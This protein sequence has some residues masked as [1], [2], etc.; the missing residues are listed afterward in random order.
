MS[1]S[2]R[3]AL[4]DF[5]GVIVDSE[6]TR[7]KTYRTLFQQVYGVRVEIDPLIMVGQPESYNLKG[8]LKS[9]GLDHN[10]KIVHGLKLTRSKILV[11]QAIK[12]FPTIKNVLDIIEH[13]KLMDIPMAIVTNS[14]SDYLF[15]AL[16]SIQFDR[17][18]F[19][20]VTGDDVSAPKPDPQGYLKAVRELGGLSIGGLAFEDSVTGVKA[21]K[22]A[23]LDTVGVL[24][25]HSKMILDTGF[26]MDVHESSKVVAKILSLFGN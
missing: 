7:L 11:D 25:T 4:F 3:Y 21:A 24:S 17:K 20:T 6:P 5:D 10:E 14:S 19:I 16:E 13:L 12:G 15:A 8:I 1:S 2:F 23:G 9:V 22:S 26:H 18:D